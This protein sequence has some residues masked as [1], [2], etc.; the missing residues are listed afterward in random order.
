MELLKKEEVIGDFVEVYKALW[1]IDIPSP[2][3]PEYIEHH[4]QIKELTNL[5]DKKIKKYREKGD[6][7]DK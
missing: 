2:T 7:H 3:V 6:E 4:E 1:E 5:V